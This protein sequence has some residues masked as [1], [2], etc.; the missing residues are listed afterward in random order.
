MKNN[1]VK[2][3]IIG[4]IIIGAII[5]FVTRPM[6]SNHSSMRTNPTTVV[7]AADANS[8]SISN[9]SFNPATLKVKKGTKVTWTNHDTARHDIVMDAGQAA[10]G[11]SSKLIGK[12]QTYSFTFDTVGTYKYHCSPHPYMKGTVEVSE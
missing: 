11:P 8:V 10:N 12:D 5:F 9:Y 6:M 4:V 1:I 3:L 7:P 2:F